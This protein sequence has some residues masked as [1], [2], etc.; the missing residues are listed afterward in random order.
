MTQ[1]H[2]ISEYVRIFI[3]F[4]ETK[5]EKRIL[6]QITKEIYLMND[7]KTNLLIENDFFELKDF[8]IN[9]SNR[10]ATI[11]NC[12]VIINLS[13][14]Q[15]NLYVKR[16]IHAIHSIL[17]FSEIEIKISIKF[18]ISNDKDFLFESIKKTNFTLFHHVVDSYINKIMIRNDFFKTIKIFQNF[19][20]KFLTK[21][22]YDNCFQITSNEKHRKMSL[23]KFS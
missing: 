5:D 13:I 18:F 23:F 11:V 3:Y 17:I 20:L 9:I 2:E 4:S 7:F 19:C 14:K 16:N 8:T 22:T 21:M 12:D 1:Q 6:T 10:K 15:R